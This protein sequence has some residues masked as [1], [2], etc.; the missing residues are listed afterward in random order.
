MTVTGMTVR[1]PKTSCVIDQVAPTT[2]ALTRTRGRTLFRM[3]SATVLAAAVSA[4][5]APPSPH[6][7]AAVETELADGTLRC[8]DQHIAFRQVDQGFIEDVSYHGLRLDRIQTEVVTD[9]DR[10]NGVNGRAKA[11]FTYR[12][13]RVRFRQQDRGWRSWNTPNRATCVIEFVEG[14]NEGSWVAVGPGGRN[15]C[16]WP[17]TAPGTREISGALTCDGT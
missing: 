4:C 3:I 11:T 13:I 7:Q 15:G 16:W 9:A 6:L 2:Y 8:G 10:L 12:A 5:E 17:T 14:R 1:R